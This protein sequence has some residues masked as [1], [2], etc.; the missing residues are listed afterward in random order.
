[1]PTQARPWSESDTRRYQESLKRV[2]AGKEWRTREAEAGRPS[3]FEDYCRAHGLC[4]PCHAVGLTWN[5]E[6][7]GFKVVGMDG[8]T[9]LF[10][11]CPVC[12]GAGRLPPP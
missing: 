9:Q 4:A 5:P 6:T 7:Q 8:D 3:G 2:R 1:V 10:E 11:E 12:G